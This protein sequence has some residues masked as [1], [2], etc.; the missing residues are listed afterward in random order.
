M[1]TRIFFK[2]S[3]LEVQKSDILN[4]NLCISYRR[5]IKYKFKKIKKVESPTLFVHELMGISNPYQVTV[6]L[7]Q[8][9]PPVAKGEN[10]YAQKFCVRA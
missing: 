8:I 7:L 1:I 4:I 3:E 6:E 5:R 9:N 2:R 10:G